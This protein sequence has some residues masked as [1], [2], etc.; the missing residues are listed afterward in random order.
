MLTLVNS[1]LTRKLN[2]SWHGRRTKF[3]EAF[4]LAF[5]DLST[6]SKVAEKETLFVSTYIPHGT[7]QSTSPMVASQ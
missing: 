7:D 4:M 2:P 5:L 1:A 6:F 3:Q